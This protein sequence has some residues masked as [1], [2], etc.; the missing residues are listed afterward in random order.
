MAV[1]YRVN[2][3]SRV[4]EEELRGAGIPHVIARGTAFFDRA[5]I[6]D[7]LAYVRVVANPA[8][9]VSLRRI[10]NTP[11]RGISKTT[12]DRLELFA[13]N[14]NCT[15]FEAAK[16]AQELA[17]LPD[18]AKG[19]VGK[20]VRMV[21]QWQLRAGLAS[22]ATLP[23]SQAVDVQSP[24]FA[25]KGNATRERGPKFDDL[26]DL[27]ETI[28]RDSGLESAYRNKAKTEE[29]IERLA[30][31]EELISSAAEFV[32][33]LEIGENPTTIDEL[34]AWLESIALVSDA[35]MID[36]KNGAVT[37]MTLHA[38][39]GLEFPVV[40]LAALEEGLLPHSNSSDSDA[41]D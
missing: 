36:P 3:L 40:C 2:A 8:D 17:D 14:A 33:P 1:M 23:V 21:G 13:Y 15:M 10:I 7:A 4:I 28:V 20:F 5:E 18:R 27:V 22:V 11:T 35:D 16:R 30:N 26:A 12:I 39:K 41:K 29:D 24:L 37:L 34:L 6:K 19:S 31:L 32:P 9:E 25:T 38:A